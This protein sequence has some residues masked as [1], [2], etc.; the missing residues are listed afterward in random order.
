LHDA[1]RGDTA[2]F[3]AECPTSKG[4]PKWWDVTVTMLPGAAGVHQFV[5][6]SHDITAQHVADLAASRSN[7]RLRSILNAT[8]DVLWDIDLRND[9]VWWGPGMRSVFGYAPDQI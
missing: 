6:I 5:V 1:R 2:T 8:A 9:R 3:T 4:A 7:E